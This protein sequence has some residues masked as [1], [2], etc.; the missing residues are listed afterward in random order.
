VTLTVNSNANNLATGTYG[1]TAFTFNSDT[2]YGTQT[3]TATLT[4]NPPLLQVA[5]LT[6][7]VTAANQ[8]EPFFPSSFQYQLSVPAGS[9]NYSI[10]GVPSWL[11]A[12]ATSGT[13]STTA[14][15]V[16][17]TV[18]AS[19]NNLAVGTY[20][21]ITITFANSATGQANATVTATLT[22]NAA[23]A[24]TT[25]C[26]KTSKV[27]PNLWWFNGVSPQP[28][29][30]VTTIQAP[31]GG[32][33]YT[34]TITEG[35]QYAQFSNKSST[36]DTKRTGTVAVYPN[37]DPGDGSPRIVAVTVKVVSTKG[38]VTANPFIL[39]LRKPYE[40]QPNGVVDKRDS[41]Y[42]YQTQ[43]HYRILDQTGAVLPY[44][45]ALNENFTSGV[46]NDYPGT[47][48]TLPAACGTSH[49]CTGT[50]N[51]SDW[52]YLVQGAKKGAIPVSQPPQTP[53]G[54]TMVDHWDGTWG[55]GSGTP[56]AG[57]TVQ[58]NT[59]Q[60]FQDHARHTNIVSP[61]P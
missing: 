55:I 15:T 42:G 46:V 51:P 26:V 27:C 24:T 37:G 17:F 61:P 31:T 39:H 3:R 14:T 29:N 58:T 33:D 11:T 7:M 54:T 13:A 5:P 60:R 57:V 4:V 2:G 52:Y 20:G 48:W 34:W 16:T 38:T 10:M 18:N 12:S 21:P 56:G 9:I 36:I 28:T 43:I 23:L 25:T 53:L 49:V 35:T 22:V 41:T 45:I 44:P 50:Y 6:N 8:G 1:P 47:N 59:W 40:L 30:Y 32:T 19:A